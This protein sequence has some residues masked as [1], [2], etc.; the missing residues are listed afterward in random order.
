MVLSFF[1]LT[2]QYKK[3]VFAQIH[4]LVFNGGGGFLHSEV[5]NMPVWLRRFHIK[6]II[7][8]NKEQNEKIEQQRKSISEP[9]NL[10]TSREGFSQNSTMPNEDPKKENISPVKREKKVAATTTNE[11]ANSKKVNAE[12]R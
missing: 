7:E 10:Q 1:G 4:D 6:K 8:F 2:S 9:Q 11:T 3:L 12:K 5:Y